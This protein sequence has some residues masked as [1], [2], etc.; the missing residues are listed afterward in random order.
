MEEDVVLPPPPLS[1]RRQT[2]KIEKP[3]TNRSRSRSGS[4]V[5]DNK[6]KKL[7]DDDQQGRLAKSDDAPISSLSEFIPSNTGNIS[8]D[9]KGPYVVY[10][11]KISKDNDRVGI[12]TV[13][14]TRTIFNLKIQGV[15]DIRKIGFGRSKILLNSA[16]NANLLAD[17]NT[18]IQMGYQPKIFSHFV[19][20]IGIIFGIPVDIPDEELSAAISSEIPII[21]MM[22]VTRMVE[23][24]R[25]PTQRVKIW[26]KGLNLPQTVKI[27]E[28]HR[29]EVKHFIQ[30]GRCYRC[31]RHEHTAEHCKQK[32]ES[33][34]RC[35]SPHE[36]NEPCAEKIICINCKGDHSP[37]ERGCPARQRAYETKRIMTIEN[38]SKKEARERYAG[39][40]NSYS[41]LDEDIDKNFPTLERSNKNSK[42]PSGNNNTINNYTESANFIHAR[43]SYARV[44]KV[45]K[46]RIR[47]QENAR[48]NMREYKDA[49]EEG[50]IYSSPNGSQIRK[51]QEI[52]DTVLNNINELTSE[53]ID[54][55]QKINC[56]KH[57]TLLVGDFNAKSIS[58][59]NT[60][61]DPLGDVLARFADINNFSCLNTGEP[62]FVLNNTR[63]AIDIA[64]SNSTFFNFSWSVRQNKI[65]NSNHLPII[66][67]TCNKVA[68]KNSKILHKDNLYND[69]KGI[70]VED[71]LQQTNIK[72]NQAITRNT[73]V[74]DSNNKYVPKPWWNAQVNDLYNERAALREIYQKTNLFTDACNL[75]RIERKLYNLI[76]KL[77]KKNLKKL[78]SDISGNVPIKEVWSKMK[79]VKKY[80][81]IKSPN[82]T[83]SDEQN[84]NFLKHITSSSRICSKP[85]SVVFGNIG[86]NKPELQI[87]DME[88]FLV[89][90]NINSAPGPDRI[91]YNIINNLDASEKNKYL[92]V[93]LQPWKDGSFPSEWRNIKIAPIP[94]R[95]KDLSD[96][97]NYRPIALMCAPQKILEAAIKPLILEHIETKKIVP[98]SSYAF[99][100]GKSTTNCINDLV[101]TIE[102][103]KKNKNTVVGACIDIEKAFDNT[104]IGKLAL[105]LFKS[106]L[107]T[108]IIKW[109]YDGM[110][111]RTLLLGNKSISVCNGIP[112]G[113]GLSPILFNIYTASLHQI[114]DDSCNLFQFA[115]DFFIICHDKNINNAKTTLQ[116]K[117][118]DF[119]ELCD[120]LSLHFNMEKI[121]TVHFSRKPQ[122]LGIIINNIRLNQTNSIKYLGVTIT[123]S[124]SAKVHMNE[125]TS[126]VKSSCKFL[127]IL[128]GCKF[129]IN[130]SRALHFYKAFVRSKIEYG[131]SSLSN[132][133]KESENRLKTCIQES[134]R[135]AL[136]LIRSTPTAIIYN[137]SCELPP[138]YR[139]QLATAKELAKCV[140]FNLPG[141]EIIRNN[142]SINTSYAK[143]WSKFENIL[144]DIASTKV[145]GSNSL[146]I[147]VD[148]FFFKGT[149]FKKAEANHEIITAIATEKINNLR[150]AGYEIFS[151]DGSVNNNAIG[152]AFYHL[153]TNTTMSFCASKKLSSMSAEVLAF[154]KTAEY[155]ENNEIQK[156]AILTDSLSGIQA[157]S[158][159]KHRNY[160]IDA[161]INKINSFATDVQ[162]HYIPG[163]SNIPINEIVDIAA[164]N[165]IQN[166]TS[167]E[168]PWPLADAINQISNILWDEWS[169]EYHLIA[170]NDKSCT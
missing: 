92:N 40:F 38:L 78:Q 18:L 67:E 117:I 83:W 63:S 25:L 21:K 161:F 14:L 39:H 55:F 52:L 24:T 102:I 100:L 94:K 68:I 151:T 165:A 156:F 6:K 34:K 13:S 98:K 91:S 99:S 2:T 59:G 120:K 76:A 157:I 81:K 37:L 41:I 97:K 123:S 71:N 103:H 69:I 58:W 132:L 26:F 33:C 9:H 166:G 114:I 19:S 8:T 146:I 141:A 79:N 32:I 90:R 77:K 3:K 50:E 148:T 124:G 162:I 66:I 54:V 154:L 56:L 131:A 4:R 5:D 27:Y 115:D 47:E 160:L 86:T 138:S 170:Q 106:G 122:Q 82:N 30:F 116:S 43:S 51:T 16:S 10:I 126:A 167:L 169:S 31:Y 73:I 1:P 135:K 60:H 72:I 7:E 61:T 87:S 42:H 150:N 142:T 139:F 159:Q 137:L 45:N 62:T 136:G 20:K 85:T 168:I 121:N 125:S 46:N 64:F 36:K 155:A 101:N 119:Q 22:R 113:S 11:D 163:H 35:F 130:P 88:S 65:T 48:K 153:N 107:N 111:Q 29:K 164:K 28:F 23:G 96:V 44:A 110:S 118:N 133:T 93:L 12:N 84:E 95:N 75:A 152:A 143:V 140:A 104:D 129:G 49:L 149:N 15:L 105:I 108:H 70:I 109:I 128:S 17:N 89:K 127:K 112:Q 144:S 147:K 145:Q 53:K 74:V 57:P 158:N 80:Q 134:L